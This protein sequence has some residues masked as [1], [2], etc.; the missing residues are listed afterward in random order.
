MYKGLGGQEGCGLGGK[1][2][3]VCGGGGWVCGGG[4]WVCGGGGWVCGEGGW[5]VGGWVIEEGGQPEAG[6]TQDMP[7]GSSLAPH[8]PLA[9]PTVLHRPCTLM[10]G[11]S[12]LKAD[13]TIYSY[14]LGMSKQWVS[15]AIVLGCKLDFITCNDYC[16]SSHIYVHI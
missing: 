14:V 12:H 2:G 1:G 15:V 4:G 3:W 13:L 8:A 6:D 10:D 7:I 16:K 11:K 5:V 9:K